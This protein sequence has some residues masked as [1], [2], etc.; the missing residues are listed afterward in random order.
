[1]LEISTADFNFIAEDNL[2]QIFQIMSKNKVRLNI[3]QNSAIHFRCIIDNK[4]NQ[5]LPLQNELSEL[6]LNVNVTN[7]LKLL[8]IYQPGNEKIEEYSGELGSVILKQ[9]VGSAAHFVLR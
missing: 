5:H 4:E 2:Q 6:G 3:M 8:S 1:M 9:H 7:D